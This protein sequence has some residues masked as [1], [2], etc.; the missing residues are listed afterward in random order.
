MKKTGEIT[1]P[2][3]LNDLFPDQ[4]LIYNLT[5]ETLTDYEV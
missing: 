5:S 3:N 2:N 1:T 4:K